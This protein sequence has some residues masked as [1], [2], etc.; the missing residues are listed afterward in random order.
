M[1]RTR[2]CTTLD[3][4]CTTERTTL[5]KMTGGKLKNR[6]L[7][8]QDLSGECVHSPPHCVRALRVHGAF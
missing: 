8:M 7:Q 4:T 1:S 3:V 5:N 6:A 2:V